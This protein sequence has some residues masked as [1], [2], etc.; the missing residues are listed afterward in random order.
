M[1]FQMFSKIPCMAF[2]RR[3][4]GAMPAAFMLAAPALAGVANPDLSAI[5]QVLGGYTD[6]AASA[7][8]EQPTLNLGEAEI[9]LDAYL[10]PFIKGWFTLSGG[11]DGIGVEEAFASVVKGLPWGLALKAGKYRLGF[12]KINPVHPHALPFI[13]SPRSAQ[14]L[15]FGPE[16]FNETGAQVSA[17]LPTPGD[18][19]SML[20]AD[21]IEGKAFHEGQQGTRLGWLGR[22]ANDFLLGERG[23]LETGI[24]GATGVDSLGRESRAWLAGADLKTKFYLEGASQLTVQAEYILKHSHTPD[25]EDRGGFYG[26]FDYRYHTQWS[27]GL[28][29][30]QWQ[31]EGAADETDRA[32]RA[33]IGYAVLEESTLLRLAYEHFLPATGD[34]VNTASLQLLFSM[35][36]HKAHQF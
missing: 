30:E 15:L 5:G 9:V 6:D 22:W 17:L 23:A 34:A 24:S 4:R 25:P 26:F 12:G 1:R 32:F 14:S 10:N 20:S 8:P 36:P 2:S 19:A 35:G 29:Y 27:G 3:F 33:F 31:P 13:S 11:E 7:D 21:V 16:G 28:L 18:W